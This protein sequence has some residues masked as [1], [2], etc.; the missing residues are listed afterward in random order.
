MLDEFYEAAKLHE[1][2]LLIC[3]WPLVVGRSKL[4]LHGSRWSME[5]RF[6]FPRSGLRQGEKQ[7]SSLTLTNLTKSRYAFKVHAFEM[8]YVMMCS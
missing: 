7:R 5:M 3:V 1:L 6:V 2:R 4:Y 8:H